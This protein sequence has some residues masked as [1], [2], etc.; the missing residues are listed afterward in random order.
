MSDRFIGRLFGRKKM[1]KEEVE[2]YNRIKNQTLASLSDINYGK[3]TKGL[4]LAEKTLG[5]CDKLEQPIMVAEALYLKANALLGLGRY[6]KAL[7]SINEG[8][9]I[10]HNVQSLKKK[11]IESRISIY[12]ILRAMI[13]RRQGAIELAMNDLQ[14]SILLMEKSKNRKVI[15][16]LYNDL[17][18]IFA[19]KGEIEEA[20]DHFQKSLSCYKEL[21][22]EVPPSLYNNLGLITRYIG[23]LDRSL[24]YF[25]EA[26]ANDSEQN[27]YLTSVISL[28]KGLTH[29][30]QGELKLALKGFEGCFAHYE[31][32]ACKWE[33]ATSLNNIGTIYEQKGDLDQAFEVYTRS[34]AIFEDLGNTI[35][36]A[37][38]LN[39]IGNIY[40]I[41]GEIEKAIS[42][43]QKSL[44]Y[45]KTSNSLDLSII[46]YNLC[47]SNLQQNNR[48]E[49]EEY[50]QE[51]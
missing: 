20:N 1:S 39:N 35:E 4:E 5:E 45:I 37:M 16:E 21:G 9:N 23:D 7:I 14:E 6:S 46:L 10:I 22:M 17:G 2:E 47:T 44:N 33:L 15:A 34:L 49:A 42:Y 27:P 40:L 13:Y 43:Y 18:V 51:L 24:D 31:E 48:K 25:E 19:I 50:L 12:K 29:I 3:F 32:F 26:I 38:C 28:N 36:Q 8:E 41:Q 30:S 11:E